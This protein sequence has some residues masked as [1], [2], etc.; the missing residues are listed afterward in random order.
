MGIRKFKPVTPGRRQMTVSDFAEITKDHPEKALTERFKSHGGRNFR[1]KITTRHHGGGHRRLYR[2]I[3]FKRTKLDVPGKVSSIEYDPNRSVRIA[4]IAYADG[5]KRYILAP[6][7][8]KVGDTVLSSSRAIDPLPG[9]SMPMG[10]MPLGTTIHN[11]ELRPG[12]G[13]QLVRSAGGAAQLMAKEGKYV[14]IRLPSTEMR[15]VLANCMAS[16]GQLG[17]EQH[18]NVVIGKAGRSRWLGIRPTVRGACMNPV[19]HN[20]GGGEGRAKGGKPPRTPWGK[21]AR[22]LRT[23]NNKR[24]DQYVVAPRRRGKQSGFKA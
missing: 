14:T 18:E 13:G 5:E 1:G 12:K 6:G 21:M 24:T 3:D 11:V 8:L 15:R 22:G 20:N 19:D 2:N 7:A 17:N 10:S 4:L 9:N 23:R 16:V